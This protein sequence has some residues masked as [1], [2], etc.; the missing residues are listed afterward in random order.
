ME[1]LAGYSQAKSPMSQESENRVMNNTLR[2]D[3]R[4][5]IPRVFV[6]EYIGSV[7]DIVAF[8]LG[9]AGCYSVLGQE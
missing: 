9:P 7:E 6:I 4:H 8:A 2:C 3:L 1:N 5:S